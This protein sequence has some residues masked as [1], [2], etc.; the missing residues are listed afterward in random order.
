MK[1]TTS[2]ISTDTDEIVTCSVNGFVALFATKS[3]DTWNISHGDYSPLDE[4]KTTAHTLEGVRTYLKNL[5]RHLDIENNKNNLS[6]QNHKDF[7]EFWKKYNTDYEMSEREIQSII[8]NLKPVDPQVYGL[9]KI[10]E[11]AGVDIEEW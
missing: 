10:N 2:Y 5:A 3:G 11:L 1:I 9:P 8:D 7:A 4:Y 6:T